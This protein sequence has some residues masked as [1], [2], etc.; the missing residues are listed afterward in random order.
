MDSNT[1]LK[2]HWIIDRQHSNSKELTYEDSI[3]MDALNAKVEERKKQLDNGD[4]DVQ[5]ENQDVYEKIPRY[6][7]F[8]SHIHKSY[9]S[10]T[11]RW[12]GVVEKIE[13]GEFT[14]RLDDKINPDTYETATFDVDEVSPSDRKLLEIGA[15]FY[16]SVGYANHNGQV[17]KESLLRFKRS[18]DFSPEELDRITDQANQYDNEINWE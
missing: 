1:I 12:T 15:V 13:E 10:K 11:Q 16:W 14:A 6:S 5:S 18:I 9:F 4:T 2:D 17:V 8:S 3:I 7:Q